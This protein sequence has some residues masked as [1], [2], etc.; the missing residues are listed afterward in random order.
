MLS[1]PGEAFCD[2]IAEVGI[3]VVE[4]VE[5]VLVVGTVVTV[6]YVKVYASILGS[7][8]PKII[9]EFGDL[10]QMRTMNGNL[11]LNSHVKIKRKLGV[12]RLFIFNQ[13]ILTGLTSAQTSDSTS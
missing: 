3:S 5:R 7:G 1:P 9:I 12:I 11:P 13:L 8:P 6:G 4:I 10:H 2:R